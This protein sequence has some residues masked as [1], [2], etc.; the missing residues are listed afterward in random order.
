MNNNHPMPGA[1][2]ESC[3]SQ[4]APD[5]R[6]VYVESAQLMDVLSEQLE[7]L[8]LMRTK[9]VLPPARIAQG[10]TRSRA[11]SSSHFARTGI[12]AEHHQPANDPAR[13]TE[14]RDLR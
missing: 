3:T 9:A 2:N 5:C 8:V 4:V 10:S 7:Y 11:G 6:V 1:E 14:R 13:A 12:H